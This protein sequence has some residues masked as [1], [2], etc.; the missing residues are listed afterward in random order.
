M[1]TLTNY[2]K[3]K[4]PK[5][6][7]FRWLRDATF[8]NEDGCEIHFNENSSGVEVETQGYVSI[9]DLKEAIK[10]FEQGEIKL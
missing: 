7:E 9:E 6:S 5:G 1:I 10:Q 4:V 2:Q 3:I 8:E